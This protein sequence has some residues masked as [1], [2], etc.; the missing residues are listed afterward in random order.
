M[1]AAFV[2]CAVLA[3]VVAS[4]S[5]RAQTPPTARPAPPPRPAPTQ[6]APATTPPATQPGARAATPASAWPLTRSEQVPDESLLGVPIYPASR[7]VRSYDAGQ[8]QRYYLFATTATFADVVAY[9]RKVLKMGG[10]LVYDVP[11]VH[12]FEVGRFREDTMAFPPGV[13]VK[14][15][16][17]GGLGG[18]LDPQPGA[19]PQRY[20]T[21]VQIVPVPAADR[22]R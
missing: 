21:V 1:R 22:R 2:W 14:D 16:T 3:T 6:P 18:Y 8:G 15:Y 12:M 4:A 13:T 20:P 10:D 5:V 11:P 7:F 19:N 9:Y 17:G